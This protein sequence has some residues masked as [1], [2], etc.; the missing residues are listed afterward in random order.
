MRYVNLEPKINCQDNREVAT[1]GFPS[2]LF[3][4]ALTL[5]KILNEHFKNIC[6]KLKQS[7]S[8]SEV[9]MCS[10]LAN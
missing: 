4:H 5:N 7:V 10:C 1:S 2:L 3:P 9:P 8:L 6:L